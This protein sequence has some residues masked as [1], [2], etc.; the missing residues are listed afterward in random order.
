MPEPGP[1]ENKD[2]TE[3]FEDNVYEDVGYGPKDEDDDNSQEE[4]SNE[5][6]QD[7]A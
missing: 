2:S 3:D 6:E 5:E 4:E 1:G 7:N